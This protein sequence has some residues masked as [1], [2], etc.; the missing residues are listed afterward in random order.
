MAVETNN[1]VPWGIS[2]LQQAI[3]RAMPQTF[4][5]TLYY[6][7]GLDL[8]NRCADLRPGM[9]LRVIMNDY[10][11]VGRTT[12]TWIN[13]YIGGAI[14]DNDISS[15]L[16]PGLPPARQWTV[17]FDALFAQ[18]T[19]SGAVSVQAPQSSPSNQTEAGLADASDLFYGEFRQPFYRLFFPQ[20]LTPP[21]GLGTAFT[22]SNFVLAAASSYASLV[23]T[24]NYPTATNAVAYF[25]GRAIVKLCIRLFVNGVEEIVPIGTTVGN[26]L[27]RYAQQI[28]SA[29]IAFYGVHLER[30]LGLA[31]SQPNVP[32]AVGA[33]YRVRLDWNHLKVYGPARDALSLPLLHGDRLTLDMRQ[34]L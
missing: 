2:V 20:N 33:S 15:Y 10:I 3:S 8:P 13:G 29:G 31:I 9:V 25:R 6:A 12:Q 11:D 19:A 7:Y 34:K 17:G 16:S 32:V 21:T 23:T 22:P 26:I 4:E 24:V 27:E 18:L 1:A 28:P 30:A 5:E 14:L